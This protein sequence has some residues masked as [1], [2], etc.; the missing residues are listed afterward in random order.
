VNEALLTLK[1]VAAL[2]NVPVATLYAWRHEGK[3][4]PPAVKMGRSLR[5]RRA[6]VEAWVDDLFAGGEVAA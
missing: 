2:L 1:D 6:D 3:P 4:M 5:F